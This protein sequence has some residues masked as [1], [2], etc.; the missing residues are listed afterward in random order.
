M[1]LPPH[2]IEEHPDCCCPVAA[3]VQ[4]YIEA[5]GVHTV[6]Q[7]AAAAKELEWSFPAGGPVISPNSSSLPSFLAPTKQGSAHYIF[8]GHPYSHLALLTSPSD[9]STSIPHHLVSTS[10]PATLPSSQSSDCYFSE[11]TDHDAVNLEMM[12]AAEKIKNLLSQL[13]LA[14]LNKTMY[15]GEI[16]GLQNELA[17]LYTTLQQQTCVL[18]N[19]GISSSQ[20]HIELTST[21]LHSPSSS[22]HAL[23]H[24]TPKSSK[25]KQP[26]KALKLPSVMQLT[27]PIIV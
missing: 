5:I 22:Q 23:P 4:A 15:L 2:L 10:T 11:G 1:Y 18:E 6:E 3:I 9:K 21:P 7:Y 20:Y 13:E 12:D 14:A 24:S 16:T 8:H 26:V 25:A 19:L 27:Y 17:D